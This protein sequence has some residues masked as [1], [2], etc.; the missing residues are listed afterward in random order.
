[1][2]LQL[3]VQWRK[4]T[5][6]ITNPMNLGHPVFHIVTYTH[7]IHDIKVCA[8]TYEHSVC[9]GVCSYIWAHTFMSRDI[10]YHLYI[11]CVYMIW[12]CVWAHTFISC[13][14]YVCNNMSH[15]IYHITF[16][17]GG[18]VWAHTF[19]YTSQRSGSPVEIFEQIL[20]VLIRIL[21][22]RIRKILYYVTRHANVTYVYLNITC[23]NMWYVHVRICN[24]CTWRVVR[25][26]HM[27]M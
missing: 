4:M 21:H 15:T 2:S 11:R 19:I 12:S 5:Y 20:N 6:I 16:I 26:W 25:M 14:Q 3:V 18:C 7:C 13:V 1:M 24:M 9:A 10:S 27:Y 8:H 17:S 22:I 23:E